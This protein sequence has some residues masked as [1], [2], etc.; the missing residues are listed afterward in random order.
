MGECT[1]GSSSL[2]SATTTLA[3]GPVA[4]HNAGALHCGVCSDAGEVRC[5]TTECAKGSSWWKLGHLMHK[6]TK[7]C[8]CTRLEE[9]PASSPSSSENSLSDMTLSVGSNSLRLPSPAPICPAC[10]GTDALGCQDCL[11]CQG[12]G[13]VN[14]IQGWQ[15]ARARINANQNSMADLQAQ[16]DELVLSLDSLD[17]GKNDAER[18]RR[19]LILSSLH[20][21]RRRLQPEPPAAQEDTVMF[22][23]GEQETHIEGS[24]QIGVTKPVE[25]EWGSRVIEVRYTRALSPSVTFTCEDG[26]ERKVERWNNRD[27]KADPQ[28][29]VGEK[30]DDRGYDKVRIRGGDLYLKPSNRQMRDFLLCFLQRMAGAI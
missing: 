23:E 2:F 11:V 10:Y 17:F 3:A 24:L 18:R 22:R 5:D 27:S 21:T 25:G 4:T 14:V 8:M 15:N 29:M 19:R 7:P 20:Q 26:S 13:R 1:K 12:V 16:T 28:N 9:A 30:Y 6:C